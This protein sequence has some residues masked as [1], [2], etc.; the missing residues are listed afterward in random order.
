MA[1]AVE[2]KV[3][4]AV[5]KRQLH[6]KEFF[7]DF[8]GLRSGLVTEA[9]F[10]RCVSQNF[11]IVLTES[12]L[13]TLIAKYNR[14]GNVDYRAF[15]NVIEEV[16][17]EKNLER[18]PTKVLS[19]AQH[20]MTVPVATGVLDT[21]TA[22]IQL[23]AQLREMF[24]YYG[25]DIRSAYK[26]FDKHN[27]GCVTITQFQ[28]EFPGG[29]GNSVSEADMQLL[30]RAYLK[31]GVVDYMALHRDVCQYGVGST[32]NPA[33]PTIAPVGNDGSGDGDVI[34]RLR[35]SFYRT[36][37]RP[38]DFFKDH[39]KLRSKVV[40]ENQFIR[41]L[42]NA[43]SAPKGLTLTASEVE[44]VVD[45]Y[46]A[47]GGGVAYRDFCNDVGGAFVVP[48]AEAGASGPNVDLERNPLMTPAVVGRSEVV[49]DRNFLGG[50]ADV[51][52]TEL[53][54][55]IQNEVVT[56]RID[57]WPIFK[58]F[59]SGVG[60]ACFTTAN[61]VSQFRRLLDNLKLGVLSAEDFD[62]LV[63]KYRNQQDNVNYHAFIADIDPSTKLKKGEEMYFDKF[64]FAK[65]TYRDRSETEKEMFAA[66]GGAAA[67]DI[68]RVLELMRLKVVSD[69]FRI[70][71]FFEDNDQ[72]RSG[73]VTPS[74]FARAINR[75]FPEFSHAEANAVG[76]RYKSGPPPNSV[77]WTAFRDE[78]DTVF[79]EKS[80]EKSPQKAV[81]AVNESYEGLLRS[82][83]QISINATQNVDLSGAVSDII[84][85]IREQLQQTKKNFTDLMRDFDSLR[86]GLISAAQFQQGLSYGDITV[87]PA[88]VS[89]LL[90]YFRD[91]DGYQ[92]NYRAF[93][94]QL[95]PNPVQTDLGTLRETRAG[96][97][98]DALAVA[99]DEREHLRAG[100]VV[101]VLQKIRSKV[102]KERRRVIDFFADYDRLNCGRV[103]AT[104]FERGLDL[105]N[106]AL[107]PPELLAVMDAYGSRQAGFV[108]YRRFSD[109]VEAAVAP[110]ALEQEPL[111]QTA[112]FLP[113]AD[114]E[115]A[116]E[117]RKVGEGE[118]DALMQ[119]VRRFG[120]IAR[121][122]RLELLP[123]FQDFDRI[124]NGCV[125]RSQFW[126]VLQDLG[127][128]CNDSEL[129]AICKRYRVNVG[130]RPDV[131]Y[132]TFCDDVRD[133]AA[134]LNASITGGPI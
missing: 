110:P 34:T 126:R 2:S 5:Y 69:R 79:T 100:N 41:G 6:V 133:T 99:A 52:V 4:G 16:F 74:I 129:D 72:L 113:L 17:T 75:M 85:E 104:M 94:D 109:D 38:I 25:T 121:A 24:K 64:D 70:H 60:R 26:D 46:K 33:A 47:R 55:W 42:S 58:D 56:R 118:N 62:L 51:R 39:D 96:V 31:E 12:E 48:I 71:E 119:A 131:H 124:N 76:A 95:K 22:L 59:D 87:S 57:V 66:T 8:D 63:A 35:V 27:L 127:L 77:C 10:R 36:R 88:D 7:T 90:T 112:P 134:H 83:N 128:V 1:T 98:R 80:L 91:A 73:F 132:R 105:A 28:R 68:S 23:H 120:D 86:R 103:T 53:L 107:S 81:A 123:F 37:V 19:P 14:R 92:I 84:D 93:L 65:T 125:S 30:V 117:Q 49:Q 13:Q 9:Q 54:G 20:M 82:T 3:R 101:W 114:I 108:D 61:T 15:S 44:E 32:F 78:V 29:L 40:T 11:N 89:T 115:I 116:A 45:R 50:D 122:R 111:A 43:C 130:G 102:I 97:D 106:L 18:S 67:V 21:D